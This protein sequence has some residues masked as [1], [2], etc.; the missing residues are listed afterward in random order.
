MFQKALLAIALCFVTGCAGT[1]FRVEPQIDRGSC[2]VKCQS[3]GMRLAGMV[4]MGHYNSGCLCENSGGKSTLGALPR[5]VGAV[6]ASS[7]ASHD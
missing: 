5:F 3:W 7:A 2:E 6:F 4:A 1:M